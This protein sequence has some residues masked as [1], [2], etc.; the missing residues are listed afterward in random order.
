MGVRS[1]AFV[2]DENAPHRG[3]LDL[4]VRGTRLFVDAARVFALADGIADTGTAGRLRAAGRGMQVEPRLVEAAVDAFHFLQ[5]LR[6]RVQDHAPGHGAA[7]RI[8]PHTLNEVD[9]RMLKEAFRQ[10]RKLQERLAHNYQL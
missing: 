10:A 6:L 7:N 4:K 8:D 1:R 9:Q 5:L 2:T 3:T